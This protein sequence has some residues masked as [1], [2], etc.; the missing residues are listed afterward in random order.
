MYRL[1]LFFTLCLQ[2]CNPF[3]GSVQPN[4]KGT[5]LIGTRVNTPQGRMYYLGAYSAIPSQV[6]PQ[7]MTLLGHNIAIYSYG[8]HPYIWDGTAAQL[9]KYEVGK[10]NEIVAVDS[11]GFERIAK[12]NSFGAVAF[13][14]EEEAYVFF[15]AEGKVIEF[16]PTTMKLV[17]Q[18][19]VDALPIE[20]GVMVGTNTY[21]AFVGN[22]GKILL[23]VGADPSTF[24]KFSERACVAVFDSK[25]KSVRYNEDRRMTIGYNNFTKD[26]ANGDLYYRPSKYI[27][28]VQDYSPS[29]K[30]AVSGGLLRVRS[31]GTYDPDFF[32]DLQKVL[33]AH[34]II[35][36]IAVQGK[37]VLVQYIEKDWKMPA[38]PGQ[39]FGC[40]TKLAMVDVEALTFKDITSL[41]KYGT[42][43]PVGEVDG[44]AYYSNFGAEDGKYHFFEQDNTTILNTK[45]EAIGGSGIYIAR[46]R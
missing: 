2:A 41:D 24:G 44:K 39:W 27:A 14:S 22:D 45:I 34:R 31:D 25:A 42:V 9:F 33:D 13:I 26:F 35:S 18:M 29:Q 4:D 23:P 7:D 32:V 11:I 15:L 19:E 1:L 6:A 38:N 12:S 36:V 30:D 40:S 37:D 21:Y 20:K 43:Y 46:L 16:N 28:R 8:E 10:D 5:I 3:G 17:K